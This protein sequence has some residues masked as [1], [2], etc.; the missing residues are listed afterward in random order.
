MLRDRLNQGLRHLPTWSVYICMA[1]PL[2]LFFWQGIA[3]ALGPEPIRALEHLYGQ[4]AL[5]YLV[6]SLAITPLRRVW[7]INLLRFR[8]AAGVMGFVYVVAHLLVWLLLDIASA[9][10]IWADIVKRPYITVGMAAFVLLVPLAM[11]STNAAQRRLGPRWGQLHK[12]AYPA[13]L[14][15]GIH[16]VMQ[17]KGWLL[18]PILWLGAI[19]LLLAL[20]LG[21]KSRKRQPSLG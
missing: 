2:P 15:G 17:A 7:G 16:Y 6:A 5:A 11:T 14:L 4:V 12:L 1:L 19:L 9:A 8:R 13:I 3:G 10:A 21:C 20:R 18:Q